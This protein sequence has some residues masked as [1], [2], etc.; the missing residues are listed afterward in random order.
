MRGL[1]I[2]QEVQNF[3]QASDALL[4]PAVLQSDLTPEECLLIADYVMNLSDSNKPWE[5]ISSLLT[6]NNESHPSH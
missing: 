5:R 4:S 3:L 1:P 2:R 6:G